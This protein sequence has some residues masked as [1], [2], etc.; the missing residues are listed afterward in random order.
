MNYGKN[1]Y[2]MKYGIDWFKE[3]ATDS[4]LFNDEIVLSVLEDER[5]LGNWDLDRLNFN[6]RIYRECIIYDNNRN[7]YYLLIPIYSYRHGEKSKINIIVNSKILSIN[8]DETIEL[9]NNIK[10]TKGIVKFAIPIKNIDLEESYEI[11][12]KYKDEKETEYNLKN[13]LYR[14]ILND[15]YDNDTLESIDFINQNSQND[16]VIQYCYVDYTHGG[17]TYNCKT[18]EGVEAYRKE[19]G[20]WTSDVVANPEKYL[21]SDL[22]WYYS[23]ERMVDYIEAKGLLPQYKIDA[24]RAA[25]YEDIFSLEYRLK[26]TVKI[27]PIILFIIIVAVILLKKYKK[28][29]FKPKSSD[30]A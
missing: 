13:K 17:P 3:N 25:N 23:D 4:G 12:I 15:S 20:T 29:I 11:L 28:K 7:S 27:L 9:P 18:I 24:I 22:E 2:N 8:M 14:P 26:Q 30:N 19:D 16:Y 5:N 21:K 1:W 6:A 10:A